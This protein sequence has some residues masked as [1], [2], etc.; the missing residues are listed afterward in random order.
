MSQTPSNVASDATTNSATTTKPAVS[1]IARPKTATTASDLGAEFEA[2]KRRE[3][4]GAF[5]ILA[6]NALKNGERD[7]ANEAIKNAFAANPG[8]VSAIDLLGDLYLEA[9]ETERALQLYQRGLEAHP[10]HAV[11]EEKLA[12]CKLDLAE[13]EADKL[14]KNV[15][16]EKGDEGKEFERSPSKAVTLSLFLPGAGQFYNEQVEKGAVLLGGYF[17]STIGWFYPLWNALGVL[18]KGQRLD[19]AA[20]LA[21]LS[22]LSALSYRLFSLLS[23]AI[24]VV[25]LWDAGMVAKAYNEERRQRL[26]L[27]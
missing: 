23:L 11:F 9:G 22:G 16:L 3:K 15:V 4:A 1:K 14:L 26:G 20:A 17:L 27:N 12:V 24:F 19:F 21:S 25:S 10:G 5:L 6:R 18:P 13:I 8:D 2:Q 7:K